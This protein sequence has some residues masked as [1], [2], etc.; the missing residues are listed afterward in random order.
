MIKVC[1]LIQIKRII[2]LKLIRVIIKLNLIIH[3]FKIVKI[4]THTQLIIKTVKTKLK[5][6]AVLKK[7]N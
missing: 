6:R 5:Q 1:I 3:F 2:C 4:F 7:K